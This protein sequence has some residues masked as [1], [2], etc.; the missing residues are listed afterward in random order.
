MTNYMIQNKHVKTGKRV[1]E[2]DERLLTAGSQEQSIAYKLRLAQIMAYQA[3]EERVTGY[4]AAPRY[5]GLLCVIRANP[6]QQQTRLAETIA[7]QRSSLVT[8]LDRLESE[9]L[10]ERENCES[11]RRAKLVSLTT[12]GE[13]IVA[14]LLKEADRHEELLC[15]NLSGDERQ[16]VLSGLDRIISNLR[17]NLSS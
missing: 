4:G 11:D 9:G 5:L 6:G 10:V 1:D 15:G 14:L 7:V 16:A 13:E 8:I 2:Q 3:F 12:K 17:G